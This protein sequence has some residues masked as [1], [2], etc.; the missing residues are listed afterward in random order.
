MTALHVILLWY[1]ELEHNNNMTKDKS[2]EKK[3]LIGRLL[4]FLKHAQILS[5]RPMRYSPV[6]ADQKKP[7]LATLAVGGAKEWWALERWSQQNTDIWCRFMTGIFYS[8]DCS[9]F[10]YQ[11]MCKSSV[12]LG[13]VY[14][15]FVNKHTCETPLLTLKNK[16]HP[17]IK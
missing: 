15:T 10:Q 11:K 1:F 3:Q 16:L 8:W 4:I 13:L 5:T 7:N 6:Q 17:L 12:E 2:E 9:I 14:K